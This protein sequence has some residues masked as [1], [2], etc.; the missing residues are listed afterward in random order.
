MFRGLPVDCSVKDFA[1][2]AVCGMLRS[3][4]DDLIVE[5]QNHFRFAIFGAVSINLHVIMNSSIFT[6]FLKNIL[7]KRN[8]EQ[9]SSKGFTW[10]YKSSRYWSGYRIQRKEKYFNME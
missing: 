10:S 1:G 8:S 6:L 9:K 4:S 2:S 5:D 3:K 7:E